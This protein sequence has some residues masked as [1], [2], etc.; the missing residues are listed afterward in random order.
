[1]ANGAYAWG[2]ES[3]QSTRA[4]TV[5]FNMFNMSPD[6]I[7][8]GHRAK[9]CKDVGLLLVRLFFL[10]D[11]V[12]FT[13][14]RHFP[15]GSGNPQSLGGWGRSGCHR[16]AAGIWRPP[17]CSRLELY[18]FEQVIAGLNHSQIWRFEYNIWISMAEN[19]WG[20]SMSQLTK[21]NNSVTD[22]ERFLNALPPAK[23][24][25]TFR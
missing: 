25:V 17:L 13:I 8:R 5:V 9:T 23:I 11:F 12:C 7:R 22:A 24:W 3:M 10:G 1:M 20:S 6:V 16:K 14:S 21:K 19:N 2:L 4:P 15:L 18:L